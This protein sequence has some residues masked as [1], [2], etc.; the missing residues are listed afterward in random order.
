MDHDHCLEVVAVRG[1]SQDVIKLADCL[2]SLKG[3][4]HAA[5]SMT[6]TGVEKAH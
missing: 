5:L 2:K 6:Y 3:V 1:K 4:Q